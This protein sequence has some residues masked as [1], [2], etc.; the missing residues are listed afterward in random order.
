MIYQGLAELSDWQAVSFRI[1]MVAFI[2]LLRGTQEPLPNPPVW[3]WAVGSS[4][5]ASRPPLA[6]VRGLCARVWC[7]TC[8]LYLPDPWWLSFRGQTPLQPCGVR[9]A[10]DPHPPTARVTAAATFEKHVSV[11]PLGRQFPKWNQIAVALESVN[12]HLI[13]FSK[14]LW[15]FDIKKSNYLLQSKGLS[16]FRI[17][18]K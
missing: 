16:F 7:L 15:V 3:E 8:V 1:S 4:A 13:I 11:A 9:G 17:K 14:L 6:V 2:Y 18:E 12:W 10:E 5:Q